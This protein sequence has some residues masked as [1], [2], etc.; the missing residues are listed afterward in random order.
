MKLCNKPCARGVLGCTYRGTCKDREIRIKDK[1]LRY[2][3]DV[4]ELAGNRQGTKKE[5]R[6]IARQAAVKA[7][8]GRKWQ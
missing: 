8:D 4:L 6:A 1:M 3:S 5:V 2:Y 7:I